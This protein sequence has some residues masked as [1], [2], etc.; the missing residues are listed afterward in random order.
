MRRPKP[1][2]TL[3]PVLA[4]SDMRRTRDEHLEHLEMVKN[5]KLATGVLANLNNVAGALFDKVSLSD[6]LANRANKVGQVMGQKYNYLIHALIPR[7][8]QS[9]LTWRAMSPRSRPTRRRT[10]LSH[11]Q[12]PVDL[13]QP[14][15]PLTTIIPPW[16]IPVFRCRWS[17]ALRRGHSKCRGL[18]RVR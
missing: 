11:H 8:C 10:K 18:G 3:S 15:L 2:F 1:V 17:T 13:W 6:V 9:V 7:G 5:I 14:C 12:P 4:G 16:G